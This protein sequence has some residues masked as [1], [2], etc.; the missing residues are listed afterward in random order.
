MN[1]RKEVAFTEFLISIM[2]HHVAIE[3]TESLVSLNKTVHPTKAPS[4]VYLQYPLNSSAL[5]A[6]PTDVS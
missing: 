6:A 2:P 5:V 1:K 3:G 4:V